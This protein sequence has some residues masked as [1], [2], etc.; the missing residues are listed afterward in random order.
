MV[1]DLLHCSARVAGM[2]GLREKPLG[3]GK[4]KDRLFEVAKAHAPPR[5][6]ENAGVQISPGVTVF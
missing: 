2:S 4:L 3:K 5:R 6:A 1:A